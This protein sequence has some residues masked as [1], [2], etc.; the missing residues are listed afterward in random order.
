MQ[1]LQLSNLQLN[2]LYFYF[3]RSCS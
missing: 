1:L 2:N 3:I